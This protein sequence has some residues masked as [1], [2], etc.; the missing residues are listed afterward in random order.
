MR[1]ALRYGMN[2]ISKLRWWG[3]GA[4]WAVT[5]LAHAAAPAESITS[6]AA[7]LEE[8]AD[9]GVRKA[10]STQPKVE[11]LI[12]LGDGP[13]LTTAETI[14]DRVTRIQ[15]VVDTLKRHAETA[16]GPLRAWLT[17]NGVEHRAYW[18]ANMI[19][20]QADTSLARA[21][22]NRSEVKRLVAN[23]RTRTLPDQSK[24]RLE[25]D[26]SDGQKRQSTISATNGIEWGVAK[27]NAPQLWALG[28]TGAGIVIAGQDTGY[29][30]THPALKG[31]YRGWNGTT[32]DHNYN[33]HDAI[34]SGG[35]S[36]GF[37]S[38]VACDDD[39]HG[40]HTMGTMVGDDGMGNQIGVAP[41][42]KWIGCR[43][44]DQGTGTRETYVECFQWL[45]APTN[46]ANANPDVSKA[47]H[48]INNSW[49][50]P[51][52]ELGCETPASSD[53]IR[54]AIEALTAAGVLVVTSAGNGGPSCSTI[55]DPPAMFDASFSVGA[56]MSSDVLTGFSSRGPVTAVTSTR[57]KP[58]VT[59]PGLNV[60]SSVPGS[61]YTS[62]SGTSMAGPHVAG[63]AALLM[64]AYPSL[65]GNPME[66]R[67]LLMRT[68]KRLPIA[69]NCGS[70]NTTVPNN[71]TGW[72][73]IDVLAA[74]NGAPGAS[75]DID[76]NTSGARYDAATDG[77]L[78]ARHL[79]GFGALALTDNALAGSA[80]RSN[81]ALVKA[82]LNAIM[83]ALD[84]DGDGQRLAAT[85]GLLILRYLLGLR[86]NAL[87]DNA[88]APGAVRTSAAD[89]EAYLQLLT[90]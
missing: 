47:P 55:D 18:L 53:P 65:I 66:I 44:M 9:V 7:A 81:P 61:G 38:V 20:V 71:S 23:P 87:S 64:Q 3:L 41:G 15:Y 48:V 58:D 26:A 83:P 49:G 37:N 17:A 25:Q 10:L 6:E 27:I 72:G 46:L 39:Y 2:R 36:C 67:R 74:Y 29:D 89:I 56:T 75:L 31:K 86:G 45:L 16:Q 88:T 19:H 4:L 5:A 90:P 57:S 40:T 12:V 35:G 69:E 51:T 68:A 54:V 60:R 11:M 1:G 30:W 77:V 8:K 79:M 70:L 84:V 52:F 42:A 85:D 82:H 21:L 78:I 63:A 24:L 73:R 43:N 22:A 34:H 59:A 28:I 13:D 50:C 76:A 32:V 14:T 33:W 80:T 62:A